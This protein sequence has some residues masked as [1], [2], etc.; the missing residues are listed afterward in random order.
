M[1]VRLQ[2]TPEWKPTPRTVIEGVMIFSDRYIRHSNEGSS[3]S[4][5]R[6]T[7]W[8][9]SIR[10]GEKCFSR[11]YYVANKYENYR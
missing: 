2:Q 4:T 9:A 5:P 7:N 6:L 1:M 11:E 10:A 3:V 8:K